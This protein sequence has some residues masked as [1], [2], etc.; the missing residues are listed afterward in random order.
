MA[1]GAVMYGSTAAAQDAGAVV[2]GSAGVTNIS[3]RTELTFTGSAGYRFNRSLGLEIEITAVP[4]LKASFPGNEV[5][6]LSGSS[7]AFSSVTPLA[8]VTPL[9][10]PGPTIGNLN[11]RALFFT[12]NVRVEIPTAIDRLTPY[13]VAGGGVGTVRHTA[14]YT[15]PV[16]IPILPPVPV[17]GGQPTLRTTVV[18]LST[19]LTGL[20]VTVGGGVSVRVASHVS[21]DGDLRYFRLMGDTDT[22]AGR[23]CV[24][25]RYRF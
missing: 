19:T 6:I 23:F 10:F 7:L 25:A 20:A 13:F 12:N 5:T 24:G 3:S 11:G 18:P 14:D 21:I 17:G 1:I 22:N 16:P 4:T 15:Y 8:G 9:I 2:A